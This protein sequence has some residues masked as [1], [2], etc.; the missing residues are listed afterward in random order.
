V[1]GVIGAKE[2]SELS[3]GFESLLVSFGCEMDAVI[4]HSLMNVAVLVA[5]RLS[6]AYEDD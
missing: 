1:E 5:F 2:G 3:P 6:M 4:W